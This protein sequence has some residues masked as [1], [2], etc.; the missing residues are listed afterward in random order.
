MDV[1]PLLTKKLT[2]LAMHSRNEPYLGVKAMALVFRTVDTVNTHLVDQSE[3]EQM[4]EL[5]QH[6]TS[7]RKAAIQEP[8]RSD[9]DA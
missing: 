1:T 7:W 5:N 2:A 6:L 3:Q 9:S 8:G 4:P